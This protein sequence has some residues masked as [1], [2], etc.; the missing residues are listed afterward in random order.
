MV[1]ILTILYIIREYHNGHLQGFPIND[2]HVPPRI[3]GSA[4]GGLLYPFNH[5][6]LEQTWLLVEHKVQAY[7]TAPMPSGVHLL[8]GILRFDKYQSAGGS[9]RL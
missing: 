4:T 7:N 2:W 3:P 5:H 1:L 8:R 6:V 9:H